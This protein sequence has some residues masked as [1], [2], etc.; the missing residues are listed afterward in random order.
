MKG[1]GGAAREQPAVDTGICSVGRLQSDAEQSDGRLEF[2]SA[3]L[4]EKRGYSGPFVEEA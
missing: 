4:L 1:C 2:A 3:S